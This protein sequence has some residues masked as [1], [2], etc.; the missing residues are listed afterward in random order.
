MVRRS[1][2]TTP[3]YRAALTELLALAHAGTTAPQI[4]T[5]PLTEAA[6]VHTD[7]ERRAPTGKAVLTTD[8]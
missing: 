4:T 6:A 7:L 8:G 2:P 1:A 3:A 5:A